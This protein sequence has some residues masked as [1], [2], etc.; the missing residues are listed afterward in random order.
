MEEIKLRIKTLSPILPGNGQT[1]GSLIDSDVVFDD[2]GLPIIPAKRIKGL[3]RDSAIEVLDMFKL[4]NV[5]DK[6]D[7]FKHE[8]EDNIVSRIFGLPGNN[9]QTC[10]YIDNLYITDYTTIY[11]EIENL[12]SSK[13]NKFI[14]KNDIIDNFTEIRKQTSIDA[15][16]QT[17][18]KHSL[19]TIRVVKKGLEFET[20]LVI[21][22]NIEEAINLLVL[23][24]INLKRIGSKRNRGFGE[25]ECS[26]E[27]TD[28]Q[29]KFWRLHEIIAL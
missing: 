16:S 2:Y 6:L 29:K 9:K 25:V 4:S 18:K 3:L 24:A 8:K 11:K 12:L 27:L 13:Y 7:F 21:N 20:I 19:R 22:H 15:E 1:F 23:A 10:L 14:N 28:N 26:L 5:T 17:A